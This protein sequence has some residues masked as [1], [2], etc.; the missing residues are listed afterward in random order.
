MSITSLTLNGN[1]YSLMENTLKRPKAAERWLAVCPMK[2]DGKWFAKTKE[3]LI[4][5]LEEE[6]GGV[7]ASTFKAKKTALW[8]TE[9]EFN[10]KPIIQWYTD[11]TM[12][13]DTPTARFRIEMAPTHRSGVVSNIVPVTED[14]Y[15]SFCD[16]LLEMH[17]SGF[18]RG[19]LTKI[20]LKNPDGTTLRDINV[21]VTEE[22]S[23]ITPMTLLDAYV[24]EVLEESDNCLVQL[25]HAFREDADSDAALH[26]LSDVRRESMEEAKSV[27]LVIDAM[28]FL[29]SYAGDAEES[30]GNSHHQNSNLSSEDAKEAVVKLQSLT[31][32][33]SSIL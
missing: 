16:E 7:K 12:D 27:F 32:A 11:G 9:A 26:H 22:D 8:S 23:T 19:V 2:G 17:N 14:C 13:V 21:C 33:L 15:D 10:G 3:D 18:M 24:E 31:A 30:S 28:K 5:R 25:V 6:E 4:A 20:R 29:D 1:I